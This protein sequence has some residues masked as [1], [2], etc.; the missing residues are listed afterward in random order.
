[1][2]LV[3][4]GFSA[5][6]A[7]NFRITYN[8]YMEQM[9]EKP[10]PI[11]CRFLFNAVAEGIVVLDASGTIIA[12]N[13]AMKELTGFLS[14]EACGN[15]IA[16][17]QFDDCRSETPKKITDCAALKTGKAH[18]SE[19]RLTLKD[20]TPVT[21]MRRARPVYDDSEQIVGA[22]ITIVDMRRVDA[23]R[24]KLLEAGVEEIHD[25]RFHTLIGRS[26]EM[27]E[28]YRM[29]R[30]ASESDVTV[31]LTGESGTGKERAAESIHMRSAR[32]DGPFVRVHC[33]A[34]SETMLESELFGHVKG[35][36]TGALRDRTGRFEAADGGTLLLDEIGDIS[37][38]LQVKLLR[39]LQEHVIE[40]VGESVPRKIDVRIIAATHRSLPEMVKEKTFR[41]DLYYRLK[42]FPVHI[43]AL[44]THKDD[45]PLLISHFLAQCDTCENKE[46]TGVNAEAQRILMAHDWP[47]NVREL[48][49]AISYA[50]VVCQG[51]TI[52]KNDLPDDLRNESSEV[53]SN[54]YQKDTNAA[55]ARKRRRGIP[56]KEEIL[57]YLDVYEWNKADVA[58]HYSVSH[59]AVWKWMK[60]YDIPK[61]SPQ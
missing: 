50:C 16:W 1:M 52:D 51:K 49:H 31:L 45:I 39:V 10:L 59:T 2:V 33:A 13:D 53:Q 7:Y 54:E 30:L 25:N 18:G 17:L 28:L 40:R 12:W 36:F 27:R 20:G 11:S 26:E 46:I 61:E 29:L 56:P 60:K 58:R 24:Q 14:E 47:G 6:L 9:K 57:H 44:R 55:P 35:A 4:L 43:P 42:V 5:A 15:S 22:V 21:V 32:K 41:E 38:S 34:L 8:T 48:E 3:G 19:C 23:L 37:P